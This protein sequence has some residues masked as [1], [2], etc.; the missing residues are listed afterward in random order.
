MCPE[1]ATLASQGSKGMAKLA[2]QPDGGPYGGIGV[3]GGNGH[4]DGYYGDNQNPNYF[5]D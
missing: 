4:N 1:M 3:Y 5:N 2:D